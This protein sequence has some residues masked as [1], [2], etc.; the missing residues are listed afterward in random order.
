[1]AEYFR[2]QPPVRLFCIPNGRLIDF[3]QT[4]LAGLDVQQTVGD[5]F[6][7]ERLVE[8]GAEFD[9]ADWGQ[10]YCIIRGLKESRPKASAWQASN[11]RG[12]QGER[13]KGSSTVMDPLGRTDGVYRLVDPL[14][15]S[16]ENRRKP[17]F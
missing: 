8:L 13:K 16:K 3:L 6:T 5:V 4:I 15:P 17:S 1:M 7:P 9:L 14:S 11:A 12:Q 10:L 2:G